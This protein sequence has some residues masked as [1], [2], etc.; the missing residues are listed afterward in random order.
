MIGIGRAGLGGGTLRYLHYGAG[1]NAQGGL[2]I[3]S[4]TD[5]IFATYSSGGDIALPSFVQPRNTAWT[6]PQPAYRSIHALQ[7]QTVIVDAAGVMWT[8]GGSDDFP[9][10]GRPFNV[11]TKRAFMQVAPPSDGATWV[12]AQ[13]GT[14]FVAAL[15]SLGRVWTVG[16]ND[17][18]GQILNG[19]SAVYSANVFYNTRNTIGLVDSGGRPFV[20]DPMPYFK[21]VWA[22]HRFGLAL[23]TDNK[24]YGWGNNGGGQAGFPSP[25]GAVGSEYQ[26]MGLFMREVDTRIAGV[27][28]SQTWKKAVGGGYHGAG[29]DDQDRLWTWGTF[30]NGRRG[31]ITGPYALA[32]DNRPQIVACNDAG[33]KWID[34]FLGE[35][36]S[37]FL[38]DDGRLFATGENGSGQLGVGNTTNQTDFVEV[39]AAG[40]PGWRF[41]HAE[42]T[43]TLGVTLDGKLYGW[44]NN[45][46]LRLGNAALTAASYSSPQLISA[47][48]DWIA[49]YA[50]E[51]SSIA[52]R[53]V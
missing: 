43:H 38:R 44:G 22:G 51:D 28:V 47:S 25:N 6:T 48:T 1:Q 53:A 19:T 49:C 50:M 15:D 9:S 17:Q 24:L 10:L 41:I 37:F 20:P 7:Y 52:I 29:I 26:I 2:G 8:A 42:D 39:T 4:P 40:V 12:K 21:D 18:A 27:F 16:R 11:W 46:A 36:C 14:E 33:R 31:P 32:A 3:M 23:S 30:A 35:Y 34:V 13:V 5:Q 45:T